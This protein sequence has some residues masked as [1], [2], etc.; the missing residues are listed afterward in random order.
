MKA[1]YMMTHK[2]GSFKWKMYKKKK[3]TRT[4]WENTKRPKWGVWLC[5][6]IQ[7]LLSN[8]RETK[9]SEKRYSW[10]SRP[11]ETLQ[12]WLQVQRWIKDELRMVL[13]ATR[14]FLSILWKLVSATEWKI[15]KG[16][17]IIYLTI[18]WYIATI[19]L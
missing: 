3:Q 8:A 7:R 6:G 14:L 5:Y 13:K 18:A 12:V 11:I 10:V 17:A 9:P 19:V 4:L 2:R 15:K 16:I 1:R